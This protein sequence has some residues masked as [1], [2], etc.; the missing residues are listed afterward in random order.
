MDANLDKLSTNRS[1]I[2][3]IALDVPLPTLFDYVCPD[4]SPEDLGRR[5]HVPFGRR[6]QVGLILELGTKA[7]CAPDK[8]RR[9]AEIDRTL[10]P[11]APDVRELIH[12]ASTYYHYP[13]GQVALSALP[14][15]LRRWQFDPPKPDLTYALSALGREALPATLP[16]RAVA[17]RRLS[18]RL[19]KGPASTR[20]LAALCQNA[21]TLLAKWVDKAWLI[22]APA[23]A[24]AFTV[25]QTHQNTA[26]ARPA[27][28]SPQ[29]SAVES[30]CAAMGRFSPVLLHGITGSGKT[31]VYLRIA[32]EALRRGEQALILVPEIGLTPQF[33]QRVAARFP[34]TPIS[35]LHSGL[36]EGERLLRWKQAAAG[37]SGIV[38]GTRLAVFTPL[39]RLGVLIVDEEHDTSFSQQDGLRYSA[40]DLAVFR[41][42]LRNIPVVLGSAT[43]SLESWHNAQESRYTPLELPQRA[44]GAMLPD[45]G[46]IDTRQE[47]PADGISQ[48]A[49]KAIG[50][51]LSRGEQVLVFINRRG[52]S[53]VLHCPVCAW[54]APC[55]RCSSRLTLHLARKK[56]CCHH[57]GHE[58]RVPAAC[59]DCGNPDI[60]PI[61]QG[62]QRVEEALARHFPDA[63]IL[64]ADRDNTRR[65]GSW[66]TMQARIH[67]GEANLVVGTQLIAKGHD[68]PNLTQVIVLDADGALFSQDFRAEERLF[69][70]LMQVAG[71]AGRA[72]KPGRVLVQ[73]AFPDHPLFAFLQAHDFAGFARAQ[74]ASRK[75]LGLPPYTRQAVLRV[76]ARAL[77]EALSWLEEARVRFPANEAVE[78]FQPV[79]APMLKKAGM[80]RAQLWLQ[81]SSRAALQAALSEWMPRLYAQRATQVRWHLDVDPSESN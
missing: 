5:V 81:S 66:E 37:K 43:P 68:F 27:L 72:D 8:L 20:E 18:D 51:T 21:T 49:C 46:L 61:G 36:A 70:Q 76:E 24:L 33:T 17:M 55:P 67:S 75:Q 65:K 6:T 73:T 54:T 77:A 32:E 25:E 53:P 56:L 60:R 23:Q 4:L 41:A 45:I 11:L 19:A 63:T 34:E 15:A 74:L 44:T 59:P 9:V 3:R 58:T 71:R 14:T 30:V 80:E 38:L 31:E 28:T 42:R 39:P 7:D 57:C 1:S 29:Q 79:A 69:S 48:P 26:I 10:P 12:F 64:R 22:V 35:V 13:K 40:R 47:K 78:I 62:T 2:A 50:Q 16:A 52:Y